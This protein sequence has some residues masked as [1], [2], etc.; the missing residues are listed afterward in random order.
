MTVLLP[1]I[2]ETDLTKINLC[3]QQLGAGR[4]NATGSVTLATSSSTTVVTTR[5]GLCAPGSVPIL[6][7]NTAAAA[8]E[9]AG[10]A[11][12]ILSVGLNTFTITH[13]NSATAGRT[14]LWAILG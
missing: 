9:V 8:A 6:V 2:T 7:P 3:I 14:F 5:T 13:T 10:G 1:A 4:S 12:Y 11:M